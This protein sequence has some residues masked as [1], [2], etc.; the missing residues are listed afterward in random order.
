M[1]RSVCCEG[2]KEVWVSVNKKEGAKASSQTV[3]KGVLTPWPPLRGGSARRRWGRE[4]YGCPK[5]F[6]LWQGSL[7]PPLRGT[8][9]PLA[10]APPPPYRGSLSRRGRFFDTLRGRESVLFFA[11]LRLPPRGC[12][13][14][15][16]SKRNR[17]RR[18][19]ARR[20]KLP[21]AG[22]L[23]RAELA[24]ASREWVIAAHSPLIRPRA[25][26]RPPSPAGEG[27]LAYSS[28]SSKISC[29]T[30]PRLMRVSMARFSIRRWASV[31]V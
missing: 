19:L 22:G 7:P 14:R 9:P 2:E 23:M 4:L 3:E 24:N 6:G 18:L 27:Y 1:H 8:A 17:R 29:A 12:A 16:V 13:R 15:R 30:S 10:Q 20:L 26:P 25:G 21:P 11:S 31:S 5:Y 28:S